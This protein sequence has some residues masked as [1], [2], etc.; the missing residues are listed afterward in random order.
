MS[1]ILY[2]EKDIPRWLPE[3]VRQSAIGRL[4]YLE[5]LRV[6]QAQQND[7][8]LLEF[9]AKLDKKTSEA[10]NFVYR[11]A[12]DERMKPVWQK[13]FKINK[14]RTVRLLQDLE[15]QRSFL[16]RVDEAQFFN[17]FDYKP[18]IQIVKLAIR[19][20]EDLLDFT[21][22][23][24][25]SYTTEFDFEEYN[26]SE[27]IGEQEHYKFTDSL[28]TYLDRL[29]EVLSY[30]KANQESFEAASYLM[31]PVS[32]KENIDNAEAILWAK[33]VKTLL[34]RFYKKPLNKEVGT[35]IS[36]LFDDGNSYDE[37]YI[38]KITK[39]VKSALKKSEDLI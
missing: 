6:K 36:V 12:V 26:R 2:T 7:D 15:F 30:H 32:R 34:F 8:S 13:L 39:D 29:K 35:I 31:N 33:K 11:L 16:Y 21:D 10:V 9:R 5:N 22:N 1:Q 17:A 25:A 14:D 20:C 37:D 28:K 4:K 23:F 27:L 18:K 3:E 24:H 19:R 38:S